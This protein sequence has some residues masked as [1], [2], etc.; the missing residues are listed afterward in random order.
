LP[1][2]P[3]WLAMA[4]IRVLDPVWAG[5]AGAVSGWVSDTGEIGDP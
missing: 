5:S 1:T 2:P 3:F 4:R